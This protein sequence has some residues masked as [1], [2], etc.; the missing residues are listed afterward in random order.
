MWSTCLCMHACA[1]KQCIHGY[2]CNHEKTVT[3]DGGKQVKQ[4]CRD[5]T[6]QKPAYQRKRACSA[7]ALAAQPPNKAAGTATTATCSNISP[8]AGNKRLREPPHTSFRSAAR[9]RIACAVAAAT[10]RSDTAQESQLAR[11]LALRTLQPRT[12]PTATQRLEAVLASVRSRSTTGAVH[13]PND[14]PALT[15]E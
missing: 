3:V 15:A 6:A 2:A 9:T 12:G 5:S 10:L 13:L 1:C 8:S 4:L 14:D 7:D 11:L